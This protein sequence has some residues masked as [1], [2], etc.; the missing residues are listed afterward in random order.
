MDKGVTRNW[1]S[2]LKELDSR[3]ERDR[4]YTLRV[5]EGRQFTS[6]GDFVDI[7][8]QKLEDYIKKRRKTIK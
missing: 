5:R 8:I 6:S 1:M 7:S 2:M 4:L 3:E